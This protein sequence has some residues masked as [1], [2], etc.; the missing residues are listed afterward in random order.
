MR[1]LCDHPNLVA[2]FALKREGYET[3]ER[4]EMGE[5]RI[6]FKQE[7]DQPIGACFAVYNDKRHGFL[8]AVY[9]NCLALEFDDQDIRFE[10]KPRLPLDYQG[11]PLKQACQPEDICF[12]QILL[13]ITRLPGA[14][15]HGIR[16]SGETFSEQHPFDE[17]GLSQL[18]VMSIHR[19]ALA[20]AGLDFDPMLIDFPDDRPILVDFVGI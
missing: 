4:R 5:E 16:L 10:E 17:P 2:S 1:V 6:V 7:S 3:R 14:L 11:R 15:L 19:E 12:D 9:Q 8:K 18:R 13:E 20:P